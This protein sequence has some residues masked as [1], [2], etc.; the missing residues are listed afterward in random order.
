MHLRGGS[1][2]LGYNRV[3]AACVKAGLKAA[4]FPKRRCSWFA[5]ADRAAVGE[6]ITMRSTST[7]RARG[8]KELI[9]RLARESR[10]P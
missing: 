3:I 6:L 5:T 10:I 9:E 4:G 7:Y 8:G 2:A 1:E